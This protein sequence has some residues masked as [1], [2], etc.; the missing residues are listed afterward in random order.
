MFSKEQF[1]EHDQIEYHK[2]RKCVK[3]QRK[4]VKNL[5]GR[6]CEAEDVKRKKE[7]SHDEVGVV[8]AKCA[9]AWL[10]FCQNLEEKA[11]IC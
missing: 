5:V 2:M 9:L 6:K 3:T 10:K 11:T 1:C 4:S 8:S 7:Q